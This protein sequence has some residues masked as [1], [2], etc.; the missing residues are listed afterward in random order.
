MGGNN[1]DFFF[2]NHV[3]CEMPIGTL[4]GN[5]HFNKCFEV[6]WELRLFGITE[7]EVRRKQRSETEFWN[8]PIF[9][10]WEDEEEPTK[11]TYKE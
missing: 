9:R 6:Q 5:R 1:Q 11:N 8:T 7:G 2:L 4:S 10:G 3:L